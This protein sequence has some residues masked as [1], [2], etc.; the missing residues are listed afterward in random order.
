MT[1]TLRESLIA[2]GINVLFEIL[3]ET[4]SPAVRLPTQQ[5]VTIRRLGRVILEADQAS[6]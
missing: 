4:R 2:K 5:G 3:P 6:G 1:Q